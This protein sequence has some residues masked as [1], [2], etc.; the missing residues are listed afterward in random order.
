MNE[1]RGYPP[2]GSWQAASQVNLKSVGAEDLKLARFIVT[3]QSSSKKGQTRYKQAK[4]S[5]S[6][7]VTSL[8]DV[9]LIDSNMTDFFHKKAQLPLTVS[10]NVKLSCHIY[11]KDVTQSVVWQDL[12]PP[13]AIYIFTQRGSKLSF[14]F[15][16]NF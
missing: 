12:Q 13:C 9:R 14:F 11:C 7:S 5:H 16:I 1:L 4:L 6:I 8:L 15:V 3:D 2:S 10:N